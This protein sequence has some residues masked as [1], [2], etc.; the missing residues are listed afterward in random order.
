MLVAV[1]Y[2][3]GAQHWIIVLDMGAHWVRLP[4]ASYWLFDPPIAA[5]PPLPL[6]PWLATLGT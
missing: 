5:P 2:L 4:G 3:L 1:G 6:H